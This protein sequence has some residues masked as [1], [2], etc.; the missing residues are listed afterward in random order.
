MKYFDGGDLFELFE[1]NYS[2][3]RCDTLDLLLQRDGF[4]V[5][6]TPTV[7]KHVKYLRGL[8]REGKVTGLSVNSNLYTK[9]SGEEPESDINSTDEEKYSVAKR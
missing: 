3:S 4:Q 6:K 9:V 7:D 1:F 8:V 2:D 5:Q